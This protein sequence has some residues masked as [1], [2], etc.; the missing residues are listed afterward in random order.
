MDDGDAGDSVSMKV[1]L[2]IFYVLAGILVGYLVFNPSS[3]AMILLA[4]IWP[5]DWISAK[6]SDGRTFMDVLRP[7]Q[8]PRFDMAA[9]AGQ[10]WG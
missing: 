6:V 1:S 8:A 5:L 4:L 3:R 10:T 7:Q 2:K 9:Q